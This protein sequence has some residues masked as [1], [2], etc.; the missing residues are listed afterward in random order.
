MSK[1]GSE[2]IK[3]LLHYDHVNVDAKDYLQRTPIMYAIINGIDSNTIGMNS[4]VKS[5]TDNRIFYL[6]MLL[7]KCKHFDAVDDSKNNI[8][9]YACISNNEPVVESI[10]RR[11]TSSLFVEAINNENQT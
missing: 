7:A 5:E 9:H 10:L 3:I 2:C 6:D 8:L 1:N 4:Q 11:S